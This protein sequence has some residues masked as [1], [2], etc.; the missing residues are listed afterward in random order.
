MLL[1]SQSISGVFFVPIYEY[2][3]KACNTKFEQL[4]RSMSS[5]AK[6]K[7]PECGSPK[8]ARELS[9]FAVGAEGAAKSSDGDAPMCGRCGGPGPCA[10]GN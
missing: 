9:V 10:G 3:C 6:V 7:C 8:T 1:F 5:E 2:T 4:V